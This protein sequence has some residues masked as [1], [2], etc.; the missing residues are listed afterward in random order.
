M[1]IEQEIAERQTVQ[2]FVP[3]PGLSFDQ[4]NITCGDGAALAVDQVFSRTAVDDHQFGKLMAV[5]TVS[6][7]RIAADQFQRQRL[8]CQKV[9]TG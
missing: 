3:V 1:Q 4:K 6:F 8:V 2:I 9:R 7:L 5:Q